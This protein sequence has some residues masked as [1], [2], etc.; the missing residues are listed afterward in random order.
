MEIILN[1][2]QEGI[3]HIN[4]YSKSS[5]WLGRELSNFSKYKIVTEDGEF[6]SIEGYWFWLGTGDEKLRNMYGYEAKKYGSSLVRTIT[7][8]SEEVFQNKIKS[9]I[10][11]KL[12]KNL[13]L[14]RSLMRSKLPLT[15]YYYYGTVNSAKVVDAGYKWII[16]YIEEIR[17]ELQNGI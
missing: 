7:I 2:S 10:K 11:Y 12:T 17:K 14:R 1:P 9:A 4:I 8:E 3:T 5:L 6:S 16:E 13:K 15:H